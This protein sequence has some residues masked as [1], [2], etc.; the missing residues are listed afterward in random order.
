MSNDIMHPDIELFDKLRAG[1][2]DDEPATVDR[3]RRH[4]AECTQCRARGDWSWV[5]D[6]M[7]AAHTVSDTDLA[8]MR[9]RAIAEGS[10]RHHHRVTAGPLAV[11]ASLAAVFALTVLVVPEGSRTPDKPHRVEA[12]AETP[13]LYENIDFYLWLADRPNGTGQRDR[14]FDQQS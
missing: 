2:L 6:R 11:A 3:L 7:A 4:L 1:L 14:S 10:T 13:D 12:L 5:T 8:G 9:A